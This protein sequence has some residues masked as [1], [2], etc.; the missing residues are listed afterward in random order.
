MVV[1]MDLLALLLMKDFCEGGKVCAP[2]NWSSEFETTAKQ[3]E[4]DVYSIYI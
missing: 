2:V 4:A 1:P 3:E